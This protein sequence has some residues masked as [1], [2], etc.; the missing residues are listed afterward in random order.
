MFRSGE[1]E[2]LVIEDEILQDDDQSGTEDSP[3]VTK[4]CRRR[5]RHGRRKGSRPT[6]CPTSNN[7]PSSDSQDSDDSPP[8]SV[9]ELFG[10]AVGHG[11]APA[12]STHRSVVTWNDLG[13]EKVSQQFDENTTVGRNPPCNDGTMFA[14]T[15]QSPG[16]AH[17][18]FNN[19]F[20]RMPATPLS[21]ANC[22]VS[23]WSGPPPQTPLMPHNEHQCGT[24][25]YWPIHNSD[26]AIHQPVQHMTE[27]FVEPNSVPHFCFSAPVK[28]AP[29][30][31]AE[32]PDAL[33]DWV[34]KWGVCTHSPSSRTG[35]EEMLRASV[36][37]TYED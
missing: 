8:M 17:N 7:L 23:Q 26:W 11:K 4:R 24:S 36:P 31:Q 25:G 16:Y 34:C 27:T 10:L 2:H 30:V 19:G 13:K 15:V 9:L 21:N 22:S 29:D 35:I 12:G 37:T 20:V 18:H 1:P 5:G 14:Q 3:A 28:A 32:H 33:V 6:A